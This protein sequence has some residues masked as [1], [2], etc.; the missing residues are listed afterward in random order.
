[1]TYISSVVLVEKILK[2]YSE[3]CTLA[4]FCF[5][6]KIYRNTSDCPNRRVITLVVYPVTQEE[7]VEEEREVCSI[8]EKGCEKVLVGLDEGDLLVIRRSLN[9]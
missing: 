9:I 8:E 4:A 5:T 7:K 1:V 2:Y 6:L 3:S